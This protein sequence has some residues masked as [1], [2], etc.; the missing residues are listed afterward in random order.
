MSDRA[1]GGHQQ[2]LQGD[3]PDIELSGLID[4][5]ASSDTHSNSEHGGI[6]YGP[7]PAGGTLHGA[8]DWFRQ[9]LGGF[10]KTPGWAGGFSPVDSEES[11][12]SYPGATQGGCRTCVVLR[13]RTPVLQGG[14]QLAACCIHRD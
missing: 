9:L 10:P 7:A 13:M 8:V 2:N 1:S 11:D 4:S 5:P 6:K 14:R 12:P 3:G